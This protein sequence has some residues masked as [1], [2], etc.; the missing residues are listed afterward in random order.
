MLI[1]NPFGLDMSSLLSAAGLRVAW[2][3]QLLNQCPNDALSLSKFI[4]P[5]CSCEKVCVWCHV[6]RS[7]V[8]ESRSLC[9]GPLLSSFWLG[10]VF[11]MLHPLLSIAGVIDL[12]FIAL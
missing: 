4:N 5:D 11:V 3:K 10:G 6:I 7:V 12:F 1:T 8:H 9:M 2:R